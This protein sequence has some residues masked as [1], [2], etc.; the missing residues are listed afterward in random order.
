MVFRIMTAL[1]AAAAA[2][3]VTFTR[4][5]DSVCALRE[6]PPSRG[7]R[8]IQSADVRRRASAVARSD[9]TSHRDVA[10]SL[11]AKQRSPT[12]RQPRKHEDKTQSVILVF[13]ERPQRDSRGGL[14]RAFVPSWQTWSRVQ[15]DRR[16]R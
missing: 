6:L 9:P 5:A 7:P 15:R 16:I 14:L 13:G 3:A 4:D 10:T 1:V 12:Q 8:A 2:D 11:E